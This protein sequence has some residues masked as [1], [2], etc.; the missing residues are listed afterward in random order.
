MADRQREPWLQEIID[1]IRQGRI[2]QATAADWLELGLAE[3]A[4]Q[5]RAHATPI[6]RDRVVEALDAA[7]AGN[8]RDEFAGLF[9]PSSPLGAE[10]GAHEYP[11]APQVYGP[12]DRR[13]NRQARQGFAA[14]N[15]PSYVPYAAAE[16]VPIP[17]SYPPPIPAV[18]MSPPPEDVADEMLHESLFGDTSGPEAGG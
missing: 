1:G 4:R 8:G 2:T 11:P 5:V 7:L 16:T 12:P 6:L 17:A 13:G 9:P 10:Q 3:Q 15:F 14:P 18:A